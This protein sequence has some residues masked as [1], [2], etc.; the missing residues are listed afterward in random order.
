MSSVIRQSIEVITQLS[1]P[2]DSRFKA[3]VS[4]TQL[5]FRHHVPPELKDSSSLAVAACCRG[6]MWQRTV[7]H[8]IHSDITGFM[9]FIQ[10]TVHK[11]LNGANQT[12]RLMSQIRGKGDQWA[13]SLS[14]NRK[15]MSINMKQCFSIPASCISWGKNA[16]D[17][18]REDPPHYSISCP[19][20][21]IQGKF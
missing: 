17:R 21:T 11:V 7:Q 1:A 19:R 5:L 13:T 8:L 3:A 15:P 18:E 10:R 20:G 14:T 2:S 6:Y 12:R 16:T 4:Q 9:Y